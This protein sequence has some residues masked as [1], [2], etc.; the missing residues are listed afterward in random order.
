MGSV[1]GIYESLKLVV[2]V[3]GGFDVR[4]GRKRQTTQEILLKIQVKIHAAIIVEWRL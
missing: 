2:A 4:Y 3:R 1:R